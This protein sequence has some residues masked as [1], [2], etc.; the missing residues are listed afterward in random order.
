MFASGARV[1]W[2][3]ITSALIDGFVEELGRGRKPLH[4]FTLQVNLVLTSGL[5]N[6]RVLGEERK[7]SLYKRTLMHD[8]RMIEL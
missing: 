5:G 2:L 1:Y 8:E 7:S 4:V 3:F 6:L